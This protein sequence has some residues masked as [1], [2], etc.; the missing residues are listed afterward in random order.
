[1]LQ[2][3]ILDTKPRCKGVEANLTRDIEPL[4]VLLGRVVHVSQVQLAEVAQV[5]TVKALNEF[6]SR[7]HLIRR[8]KEVC[9]V[10]CAVEH[11]Q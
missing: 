10:I 7:Y 6:N 5:A 4:P 3:D 11:V 8:S 1:M 2:K 9:R